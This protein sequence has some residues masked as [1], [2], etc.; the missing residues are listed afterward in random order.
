[1]PL[2]R[3]FDRAMKDIYLRAKR[4]CGYNASRFLQMLSEQGGLRTAKTLLAKTETSSGFT[5]PYELARLELT[6]EARARP[7]VPEPLHN[8]GAA[9]CLGASAGASLSGRSDSATMTNPVTHW[10]APFP[11]RPHLQSTGGTDYGRAQVH[12]G[13]TEENCD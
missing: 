13:L 2:E 7:E 1:M 11:R 9:H 6:V 4:Q 12:F 5:E 3:E 8:G 10:L